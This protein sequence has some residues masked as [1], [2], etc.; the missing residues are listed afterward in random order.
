MP[1]S[2]WTSAIPPDAARCSMTLVNSSPRSKRSVRFAHSRRSGVSATCLDSDSR[3][4]RYLASR[5]PSSAP[6]AS[7]F[8]RYS[9]S[10][11]DSRLDFSLASDIC[12]L[13]LSDSS[14]STISGLDVFALYRVRVDAS[15]K[16]LYV[17]AH[18]G[19][20][21]SVPA[22]K[23]AVGI[24]SRFH[25]TD[26]PARVRICQGSLTECQGSA[27]KRPGTQCGSRRLSTMGNARARCGRSARDI[28]SR[29][30]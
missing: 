24:R 11:V 13:I 26:Y 1:I 2:D 28:S 27:I 20:V 10:E 16:D 22:R 17:W 6:M 21:I 8:A 9:G 29:P 5:A 4:A 18:E 3:A 25:V 19:A 23:A 12:S 15:L 7:C 14:I 30:G